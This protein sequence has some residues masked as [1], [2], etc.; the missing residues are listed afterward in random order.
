MKKIQSKAEYQSVM[1]QIE[2]LLKKT[3]EKGGFNFLSNE[4]NKL[5][6]E[7]S[8]MAESYEDGIPV[9]PLQNVTTLKEAIR[10][11]MGI[12]NYSQKEAANILDVTPAYLSE[13]LNGKKQPSLKTAAK[14]YYQLHISAE[15]IFALN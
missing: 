6:T 14:L 3:T 9:M 7:Y 13:I 4:E 12:M 1:N 8:L 15:L 2:T 10:V 5:L 11:Q